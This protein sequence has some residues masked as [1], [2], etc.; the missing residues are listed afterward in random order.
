MQRKLAAIMSADVVGY[1]RLIDMDE[2]GTHARV[3]S[4]LNG[5]LSEAI[6][7]HGGHLV[8]QTGDGA[9]VTFESVVD[10]VECSGACLCRW[11]TV[12]CLC[13]ACSRRSLARSSL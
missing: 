4:L 6:S 12:L 5:L 7:R 3:K 1:S 2:V 11:A 10:A 8:K 9:L 13:S